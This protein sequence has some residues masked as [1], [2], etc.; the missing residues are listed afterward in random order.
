MRCGIGRLEACARR[1]AAHRELLV[2]PGGRG[3]HRAPRHLSGGSPLQRGRASLPRR[4]VQ[5]TE[6]TRWFCVAAPPPPEARVREGEASGALV[7][8]EASR[9][10]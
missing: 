9:G 1:V 6:E 8:V 7:R 3:A 4:P 10:L 2:G 5:A